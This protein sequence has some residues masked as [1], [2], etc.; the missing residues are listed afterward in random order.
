[1][2]AEAAAKQRQE[3]EARLQL[4]KQE[5]QRQMEEEE[6]RRMEEDILTGG[7]EYGAVLQATVRPFTL[8]YGGAEST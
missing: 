3:M 8:P 1:M 5:K 7:I 6:R 2:V 4:Q